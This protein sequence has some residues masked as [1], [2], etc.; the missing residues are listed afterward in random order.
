M[1]IYILL[2]VL[3]NKSSLA[4]EHLLGVLIFCHIAIVLYDVRTYRFIEE[5][6]RFMHKFKVIKSNRLNVVP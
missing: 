6:F 3:L 2:K 5:C 4:F 1:N